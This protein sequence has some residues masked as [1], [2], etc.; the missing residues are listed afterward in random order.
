MGLAAAGCRA[1]HGSRCNREIPEV[2]DPRGHQ[3]RLQLQ[4]PTLGISESG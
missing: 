2:V 1:G 3:D 4:P